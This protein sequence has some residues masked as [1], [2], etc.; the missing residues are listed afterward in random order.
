MTCVE[1]N[2]RK[3][4]LSPEVF[5]LLAMKNGFSI[6]KKLITRIADDLSDL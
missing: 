5:L 1:Y 2:E 3:T 4:H 6:S